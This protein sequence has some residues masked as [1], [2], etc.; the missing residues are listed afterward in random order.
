MQ[1]WGWGWWILATHAAVLREIADKW[2]IR[3]VL[4]VA[5]GRTRGS[6]SRC[7]L[8]WMEVHAG[9][10][11]TARPPASAKEPQ[12]Q[13]VGRRWLGRLTLR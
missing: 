2:G 13:G 8:C 10:W 3:R 11:D 1:G 6:Q 5:V 7:D 9:V 4:C 12:A